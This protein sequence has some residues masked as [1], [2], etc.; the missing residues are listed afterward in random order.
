MRHDWRAEGGGDLC[1]GGDLYD[2][3]GL[4]CFVLIINY[5]VLFGKVTGAAEAY[6][7]YSGCWSSFRNVYG[8]CFIR[9]SLSRGGGIVVCLDRSRRCIALF[10][11]AT[12]WPRSFTG[13]IDNLIITSVIWGDRNIL[14]PVLAAGGRWR[15]GT[16]STMGQSGFYGISACFRT[17]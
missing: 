10:F 9:L 12:A 3:S 8:L 2:P 17:T 7:E 1:G 13:L 6:P 11:W 5:C 14:C 15:S 4:G 16:W